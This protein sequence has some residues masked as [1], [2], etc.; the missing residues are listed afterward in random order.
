MKTQKVK[1]S[2]VVLDYSIYPRADVDNQHIAYL[3]EA[4]DAGA[5]LPPIVID[6]KTKRV[7]DGFHRVLMWLRKYRDDPNHTI[8][9]VVKSYSSESEILLDAI[10]YNANHGR[11]LT[12]YDRT[13]C[14]LLADQLHVETGELASALSM[15]I[16][17]IGELKVNRVGTLHVG[18]TTEPIPLKRTIRHMSGRTMTKH[19]KEINSHLSGMNQ[20]FYANQ[21]IM[22]IES[23]LLDFDDEGLLESLAKLYGML[24]KMKKRLKAAS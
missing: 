7:V 3:R 1:L 15:T 14:I 13:H 23:D 16:E 20:S 10:R 18:K 8:E 12:R 5:V 11:T 21:L 17:K 24:D 2:E 6:A 22:L 4:E 9:V 19:Q